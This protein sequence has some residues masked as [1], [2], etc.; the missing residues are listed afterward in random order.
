MPRRFRSVAALVLVLLLPKSAWAVDPARRLTQYAHTAWRTQDG[1]FN[2]V[3]ITIVQTPDGYMWIGTADGIVQFDGDR[4]VRWSP[5]QG[6]RLPSSE[7]SDLLTARDGSVWISAAGFVSRWKDH[8]LV[9]YA[10]SSSGVDG[11][12]EDPEGTVWVRS[13]RTVKGAGSV[14]RVSATG[15]QCLRPQDGMPSVMVTALL[16]DRH[17]ALWVGADTVLMRWTRGAPAA[18]PLP[19]L[20]GNAGMMGVMALASAPDGALWVGVGK[21]GPGLGLQRL[22]DGRWQ[23]FD[24]PALHGSS[25][26]VTSLLVDRAG[27]LWVG[28]YDRGIYRIL[29][30]V[31]DHFDRTDG[32]SG[33][34]VSDLAEDREGNLWVVTAQGVD[35]FADT[36]V[37]SVSAAEGLCSTEASSVIASRDGSI[38]AGGESAL[39]RLRDGQV[40]C[41]RSG[42]E[43]PGTQVTSLFEDHAG[44]L[45]VGL[46]QGLWLFEQGR[47]QQITRPDARPL[48]LV[49]GIAE[50]TAHRVWITAAGPPR[51]LMRVEGLTVREDVFEPAMPRRVAADPT[52]GLWL[53][54]FNGDLAHVRDGRTVVHPFE[55]PEG[56]LLHQLVPQADG[57]VLAATTYG[58]VGWRN[59]TALTLTQKNGLPCE[60][61]YAVAFDRRGDL[62]LYMN[63][64]L[65]VMTSRDL[66]AWKQKPDTTVT[67][68]TL[69]ALDGVRPQATSFVAGARS[70]DGRLWFANSVALQVL[71][72]DRMRRNDVPPPVRIE[73]VVADRTVWSARRE[74]RLPPLT[75]DLQIN[76][77]GLSFVAPQKVRFRYRLEGRDD[78]WQEP[79]SRRQAFYT[80]LR[81][82]TYRFRVIASNND[83]VWNEEG[84]SLAIVIAPAWYQTRHFLAFC[85]VASVLAAWAAYRLR[86]RQMARAL[87]A[88]FDERLEE[89]TRMAR[90][91]HDTLLQTLQGTRMI[92]D[93]AMD[94]PEDAPTLLRALQQVSTWLGRATDEGRAAV[95]ALRASTTATNDLAAAFQRAAEDCRQRGAIDAS[96]TVTGDAREMHPVVR[97]EIYRIGYEAIRNACTHSGGQHLTVALNYGRDLILR[98]ADDGVGMESTI[99]ESGKKGHFGLPGMRERAARIGASLTIIS[100]PGSGTTIVMTVP[101]RVIFRKSSSRV[102]ER[103]RS[104]LSRTDET[105]T[106]H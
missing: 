21:A 66:Q 78:T 42:R 104:L 31:V 102:A 106:I 44:R 18:Y 96:L 8:T 59:G 29:G 24:T 65:G 41:Y 36:P 55:H 52:G 53:G 92:A 76:Y 51:I 2:S 69:D 10:T 5:D 80:D 56:A 46:D 90:D 32:L 47:F 70:S 25:L 33:D 64:A 95:N 82:G 72:P 67:I 35:R 97:D 73:Q 39:T 43:L 7:V 14:C 27:A 1:A 85:V 17:G 22:I 16:A 45:W 89:R 99:A 6:Q 57:S 63:C 94:R 105:S 87:T 74:L 54:L 100:A 79:G 49:T 93:T 12:S 101:G 61:V 71:D 88:R 86:M 58:L 62:W 34:N 75:R 26:V 9:S 11:L 13:S 84:A 4:F 81:P 98:V 68:R 20:I 48:G 23:A 60:Q 38:W 77:V 15:P 19:G 103:I 28:T 50:D 91:L 83:G 3:P 40:T 30:D 37:A